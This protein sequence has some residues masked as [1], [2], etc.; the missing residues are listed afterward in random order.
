MPSPDPPSAVVLAGGRGVRM[1]GPKATLE[2]AGERLVDRAVR[3]MA[4]VCER[5][6]VVRGNP[7]HPPIPGLAV[8]QVPD[9]WPDQGAL[10]GLHAGLRASPGGALVLA[11]DMPLMEAGFLRALVTGAGEE[12]ALVP[13]T[14]D[15]LQ[16]LCALYRPTCLPAIEG[17]LRRGRRQVIGF[18]P[19]IVAR[20]LD[21]DE[22]EGWGGRTE[23]FL[24]LNLP[25][26]VVRAGRWLEGETT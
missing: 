19:E 13:R 17:A 10:G 23:L 4:Q 1:G 26:D 12:D 5:V 6:I 2:V 18:Y 7:A 11:C 9:V 3:T 21:V 24:N 20:M 15:G 16:P 14:R 22:M 25:A 8:P